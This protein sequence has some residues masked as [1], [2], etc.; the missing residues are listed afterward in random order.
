[1]LRSSAA[2][3]SFCCSSFSLLSSFRKGS[4]TNSNFAEAWL[5]P[6]WTGPL[7]LKHSDI[8]CFEK[9]SYHPIDPW[10][11]TGSTIISPNVLYVV[12]MFPGHKMW[13]T[14]NPWLPMSQLRSTKA[15]RYSLS[16]SA[17]RTWSWATGS[18]DP[19]E[20]WHCVFWV[21]PWFPGIFSNRETSLKI[22]DNLWTSRKMCENLWKSQQ[23]IKRK[24]HACCFPDSTTSNQDKYINVT[25][26]R[27]A[28]DHVGV[29]AYICWWQQG[30]GPNLHWRVL[31]KCTVAAAEPRQ[32]RG[33]IAGPAKKLKGARK[34]LHDFHSWKHPIWD[35][36]NFTPK[37]F[38]YP[39]TPSRY[40]PNAVPGASL[41]GVRFS[42]TRSIFSCGLLEINRCTAS[43][44]MGETMG[45]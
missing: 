30:R 25:H 9:I 43:K 5:L 18:G 29:G 28:R 44:M 38:V 19:S 35:L 40:H 22:C 4:A 10:A 6:Q 15:S 45:S 11:T 39:T 13:P 23:Q 3:E 8:W 26:L 2:T 1:M 12:P 16:I 33:H 17:K 7:H 27:P 31:L 14:H 37:S 34:L 21:N 36:H 41:V 20:K 32:S 42:T 24:K